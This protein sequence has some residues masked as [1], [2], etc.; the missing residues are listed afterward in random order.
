VQRGDEIEVLFAGF[1][2][3]EEFSLQD[4]F[5][6]FLGDGSHACGSDFALRTASSRYCS[7][8]GVT[9]GK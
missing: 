8:A 3:A 1:V 9:V 2:V 6:E 5:E 7:G 4:V